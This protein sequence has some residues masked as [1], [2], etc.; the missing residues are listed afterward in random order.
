M[1]VQFSGGGADGSLRRMGASATLPQY[2]GGITVSCWFRFSQLWEWSPVW[3]L[4]TAADANITGLLVSGDASTLEM[5]IEWTGRTLGPI[6]AGTWYWYCWTYTHGDGSNIESRVWLAPMG[7]D[8]AVSN[9]DQLGG[10]TFDQLHIGGNQYN[11]AGY[12]AIGGFKM[13]SAP[14]TDDE[15]LA[16]RWSLRPQRTAN[17]NC[18]YPLIADNAT[19]VLLDYSGNGYHLSDGTNNETYALSPPVSWG[20]RAYTANRA[21]ILLSNPGVTD[22][23]STS[24]RPR[25]TI[26]Y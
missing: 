13:W 3:T 18:W 26:A 5:N 8:P 10:G 25:V 21:G 11:N 16:E 15:A 22:I 24:V 1:A 12:A 6:T 9:F 14:L 19:D 2:V 4:A 7:S 20:G 17:L 23:T